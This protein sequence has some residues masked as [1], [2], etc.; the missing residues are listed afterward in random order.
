MKDTYLVSLAIV[1]AGLI[2]AGSVFYSGGKTGKEASLIDGD[3]P[4]TIEVSAD[5]DPF[6][7]SSEAPV[8]IIEFSDFECPYCGAFFRNTLPELEEK[9]INTGKVKFVYRDFPIPSH[10]NA[11]VAAEAAQCAGDENKYWEMHDK[12][13][14][15]QEAIDKK[16]LVDYANVLGLNMN[17]FN[18]CL[19]DGK[20][21]KEVKA[22]LNDGARIGVDGT[23]TFFINGKKLVGA[24]PFSV[25][26]EIIEKELAK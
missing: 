8:V 16:N 5:D 24:Q 11:Q 26:E 10:K 19:D 25:F 18:Q 20:Y 3:N 13:F 23:P 6:R 1:A 22:D 4:A 12:I 9:Y 7:G 14:E 15:N 21:S 2:I 17:D